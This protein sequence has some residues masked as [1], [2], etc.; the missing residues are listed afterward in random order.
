MNMDIAQFFD[1]IPKALPL[2]IAIEELIREKYPN[3]IIKAHKTQISFVNK[4]GFAYVS[5]PIRKIKNRPDV[6]IILTFGLPY[7]CDCPRIAA[8]VEPYP[9]RWTHH[10]IIENPNDIDEQVINWIDQSYIYSMVK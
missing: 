9:N 1:K 10:I 5:L 2:Y 6:Y 3:V 8:A 4:H 7:R